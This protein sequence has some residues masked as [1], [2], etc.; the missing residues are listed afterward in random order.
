LLL[1][2]LIDALETGDTKSIDSFLSLLPVAFPEL[3]PLKKGKGKKIY[4]LLLPFLEKCKSDEGLILF[5][6]R[7][8][9]IDLLCSVPFKKMKKKFQERGFPTLANELETLANRL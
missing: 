7:R 3:P 5:L 8:G 6:L 1:Q 2:F 4:Q 9:K